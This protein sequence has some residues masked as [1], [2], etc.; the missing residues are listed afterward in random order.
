MIKH[1]CDKCHVEITDKT[2]PENSLIGGTKGRLGRSVASRNNSFEFEIIVGMNGTSNGV[3]L[4]KYCI[5]DMVNTAD[6]RG[7]AA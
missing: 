5:I 2:R 4:C 6:D 3:D 1:F 7:R